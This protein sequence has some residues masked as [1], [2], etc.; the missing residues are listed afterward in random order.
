MT[1]LTEIRAFNGPNRWLSNFW[2]SPFEIDGRQYA[3]VEHYYQASKAISDLDHERVR[4]LATPGQAK[5]GGQK[6]E[7]RADWDA[8][9]EVYML[10]GLRK[11]FAPG[12]E[13]GD[14]LQATGSIQLIEWN[15]WGDT[16]WGVSN[17]RGRNRLGHLLMQVRQ[18]LI[19]RG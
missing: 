3:T 2:P 19:M 16:Y 7:I 10:Q 12:T 8:L 18:E 1:E 11:K 6:V 13:L 4:T 5:R 9:K 17:G 14:R 15:K